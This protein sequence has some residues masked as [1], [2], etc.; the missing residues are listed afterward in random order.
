MDYQRI[1]QQA[2]PVSYELDWGYVRG[3]CWG[4]PNDIKVVAT[5]GWLDNSHSFLP[6]AAHWPVERGGF[7][8]LDWA[9]HG[10]S[11]HRPVGSYYHFIDYAYDLW[12]LIQQNEWQNLTLLGHSMGGF[13]SNVVASL[14]SER[15]QRVVLIEAFGLLVSDEANAREQLRQGFSS[16]KRLEKPRWRSYAT[17]EAATEARAGQADFPSELVQLLVERGSEQQEDGRWHWRADARVKTVSAYRL[18][19]SDVDHIMSELTM[20]VVV[21][22]GSRGYATLERALQRWKSKVD[23]V[24]CVTFDGGH[25]VHMEQ[26]QKTVELLNSSG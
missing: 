22:R 9:G 3:L 15:V 7:L 20:P 13:V 8:A 14:C 17:I 1:L 10:H 19:S 25:H 2:S 18:P 24:R 21:V 4:D 5:H 26:P 23:N 11:D 16:R 6:M 12:H